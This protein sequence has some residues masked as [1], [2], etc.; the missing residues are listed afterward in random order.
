MSETCHIALSE[1]IEI[2]HQILFDKTTTVTIAKENAER[3]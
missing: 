2:G 1:H 3:F